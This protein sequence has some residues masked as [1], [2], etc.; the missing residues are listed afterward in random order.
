MISV[1][2]GTIV[3]ANNSWYNN[4]NDAYFGIEAIQDGTSNTA[5]FSERLVGLNGSPVIK[6]TR[7]TRT[8]GCSS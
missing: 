4:V 8:G 6:A 7:S 3:A 2:S 5:M 1:W